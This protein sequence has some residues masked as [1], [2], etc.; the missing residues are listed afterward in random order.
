MTATCQCPSPGYCERFQ[1]PIGRRQYELCKGVNCTPA[2][3]EQYRALYDAQAHDQPPPQVANRPALDGPGTELKKLL[4][5]MGVY[6][7]EQCGCEHR[8]QLMNAW[9]VDG[10]KAQRS[11]VVGWLQEA[12]TEKG[13]GVTAA[14]VLKAATG[15]FWPNP[16]AP[17]ESLVDEAIRRSEAKE[18]P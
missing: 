14:A 8:M 5:E 10:C 12:Q 1:R 2:Q 7:E 18:A 15:S 6:A 17:F 4:Q 9:G 11:V 3:S 16:I 13:W